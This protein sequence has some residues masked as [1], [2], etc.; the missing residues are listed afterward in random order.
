MD[1]LGLEVDELAPGL[2]GYIVETDDAIYV[3][4]IEAVERGKGALTRYLD[5]LER[6]PKAV[7]IP[8]VL[9]ERL[10]RYLARRGYRLTEEWA[11]EFNTWALV[12]VKS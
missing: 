4:F 3:P 10:E 11:E 2:K 6:G 7:K 8:T 1:G 9:S 5:G 12:W